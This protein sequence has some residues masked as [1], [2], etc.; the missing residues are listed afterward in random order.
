MS[1]TECFVLSA[2]SRR[3]PRTATRSTAVNTRPPA[4][5]RRGNNKVPCTISRNLT[6]RVMPV[7]KNQEEDNDSSTEGSVGGDREEATHTLKTPMKNDDESQKKRRH[8]HHRVRHHR[9]R[10]QKLSHRHH[11]HCLETALGWKKQGEV[12]WRRNYKG[13]QRGKI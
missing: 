3:M 2:A 1:N 10:R 7:S 13:E 8:H 5:S 12:K 6:R 4:A 9:G 11:R